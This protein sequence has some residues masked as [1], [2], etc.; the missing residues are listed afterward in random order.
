[1]L[2][3]RLGDHQ[4]VFGIV[5]DH[6]ASQDETHAPL[7]VPAFADGRRREIFGGQPKGVADGGAEQH[8]GESVVPGD[9]KRSIH[10]RFT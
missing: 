9:G 2:Q 7:A 4:G 1:M 6:A 3:Q 5:A 10:F 8:T